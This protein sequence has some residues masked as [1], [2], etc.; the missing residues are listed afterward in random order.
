M[1]QIIAAAEINFRNPGLQESWEKT[2]DKEVR[3]CFLFLTAM[4]AA[5]SKSKLIVPNFDYINNFKHSKLFIYH[6]ALVYGELEM[7]F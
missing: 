2:E 7:G 1:R 4:K 5:L 6:E 3:A